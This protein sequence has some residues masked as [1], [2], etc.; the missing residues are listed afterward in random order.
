MSTAPSSS[1]TARPSGHVDAQRLARRIDAL[2]QFGGYSAGGVN[3]QA[4]TP[5]D[6][7][8]QNQLLAWAA[9]IGLQAETDDIGNLFLR[10]PG[11]DPSAPPVMAGSHIDTQPTGGRYD[12]AYGVL[13]ALEAVEAIARSG[14]PHRHPIDVVSWMNEEGSRFAPGMS[15]SAVYAGARDLDTVL[16]TRDEAGITIA[17]A[18][19]DVRARMPQL[20]RRALRSPI[21]AYIEPHIEQGPLLQ[22][23]GLS[24]G[25]VTTMQGKITFRVTVQGEAAHAGTSTRAQR[26]DALLSALACVQALTQALHDEED[27]VR[28]TVGRFSVEP[29]AP[30]VVPARVVFSVDLR[31]PDSARLRSMGDQVR[32]LCEANCGPCSVQVEELSYAPS[33]DFSEDIQAR[34]REA[35]QA[36]RIGYMD[37]PS[38]AGHDSRYTSELCPTG[39]LFIACKDGITHNEDESATE[40][41]MYDGARVLADVL[42]EMAR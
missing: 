5:E 13:A 8:G 29:N 30:S 15:G 4:L 12:G 6:A 1:A 41:D 21:A 17:Q 23:A 24:V 22:N 20:P 7:A 40:Q 35:A 25:V 19:A 38:S 10:L 33:L 37:L 31:F 16:A 32:P 34:L 2:A 3:R 39:M 26:K 18:L 28:L 14:V 36:L 27:V 42:A 9:D 11:S